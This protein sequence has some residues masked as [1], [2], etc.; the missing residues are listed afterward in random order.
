MAM[1]MLAPGEPIQELKQTGA[2][3]DEEN[4][5]PKATRWATSCSASM[6]SR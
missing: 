5:G 2:Q 6:A 1:D 3:A 4:K